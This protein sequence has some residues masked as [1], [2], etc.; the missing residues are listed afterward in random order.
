MVLCVVDLLFIVATIVS[1]GSVFGS[2][3][4]SQ[5]FSPSSFEIILMGMRELVALL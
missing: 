2:C 5:Y 4:A 3:Y 1:G